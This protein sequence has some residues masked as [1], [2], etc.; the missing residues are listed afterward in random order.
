M[1]RFAAPAPSQAAA[2]RTLDE[3]I[4]RRSDFLVGYQNRRYARRYRRLVQQVRAAE[5]ALGSTRLAEA[6]AR[7]YFKLMAYKDEY[8]VA[9][10]YADPA[11]M[12]TI[13]S[14]FEGDFEVNFHLAPP[15]TAKRDPLSGEPQKRAYGPAMMR[16]FRLLA[17]LK[18]LRG[19][20]LDVFAYNPE[21]G[22]ERRLIGEYRADIAA[23]L[24]NLSAETLDTAVEL[25]SLP[26]QIRG[27]GHVKARNIEA[28]RRRREELRQRLTAQDAGAVLA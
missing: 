28:A 23:I 20:F 14:T 16:R 10:L 3:I 17:R 2:A 24:D 11:F 7:C 22:A 25:A 21:R 26:E 19:T 5:A 4:Q 6:V 1:Q 15:L 12:K 8:E 13:N 18:F 27:Y 9:R